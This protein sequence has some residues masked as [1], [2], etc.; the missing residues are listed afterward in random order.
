[1][2]HLRPVVPS[3]PHTMPEGWHGVEACCARASR[4]ST[5]R[6][7]CPP[8]GSI[9][10]QLWP[11]GEGLVKGK[12]TRASTERPGWGTIV[13][14]VIRTGRGLR[15]D[16]TG[17]LAGAGIRRPGR[18][19]EKACSRRSSRNQNPPSCVGS[20][21]DRIRTCSGWTA[22]G[23]RFHRGYSNSLSDAQGPRILRSPLPPTPCGGAGIG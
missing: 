7:T 12:G 8:V 5:L 15:Q 3:G 17:P 21:V 9:L 11:P 14:N 19:P 22:R 16:G 10:P 4:V 23:S 2:P 1:M 18:R 13:N 6:S 20:A